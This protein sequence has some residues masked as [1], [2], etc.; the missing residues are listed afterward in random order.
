MGT[1]PGLGEVG[2]YSGRRNSLQGGKLRESMSILSRYLL[3]LHVAPFLFALGA[4]TGIQLVQQVA[5]RFSDLVGKGLPWTVIAEVFLLS[6][7]FIVALT[8]PMATLVA[9][10]FAMTRLAS[11]SEITALRAGG[12]S[13]GRVMRPLLLAGA[14]LA[15]GALLFNDQILPRTNHR[16]RTLYTDIG[17]KKPTFSLSEQV[18]NEVQR[19]RFFLRAAE[20]D[21]ATFVL[22]DVTI[23]DL[24]DQERKRVI[25]ADSGYLALTEN[26]E[27]AFLTLYDGVLH[28]FDRAEP[29][30]FQQ[31]AF[32]RDL[33]RVRGVG[34]ELR[35]TLTDTF[36]GDREMSICEMDEVVRSAHR[37]RSLAEGRLVVTRANG[38]RGLVGLAGLEVDTIAAM[39]PAQP[40]CRLQQ[41][42]GDLLRA[43]PTAA[44]AQDTADP[45]VL[46]RLNAPAREAWVSGATTG[47]RATDDAAIQ[48]RIRSARLRAASY[49]VEINKKYALALACFVFVLLGVP[50]SLRFP[51]GGVG[52]VIGASFVIFAIYYIGLIGGESLADR[53]K[54]PATILWL[55]NAIFAAVGFGLLRSASRAGTAGPRAG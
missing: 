3:R 52:L 18:I 22:R 27:D 45:G 10:L 32:R 53:L 55:P 31:T 51:R 35:R 42:I 30:M 13:L 43:T 12:V 23:F 8:L 29:A 26:Q 47:L 39:P 20:I 15:A 37:E 6:V 33:I 24:A 11:D 14:V 1:G 48:E 2:Q 40:W 19:N 50:V 25:Y 7:P 38:L 44:Q 28:E 17:R 36:K 9:V 34:N 16:L 49:E 5:R 41:G 4:L 46:R 54:A 21:P